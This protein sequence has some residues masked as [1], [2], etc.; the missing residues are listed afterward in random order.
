MGSN[1]P[2]DGNEQLKIECTGLISF[3][4][5]A[6][7]LFSPETGQFSKHGKVWTLL[8]CPLVVVTQMSCSV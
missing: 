8:A 4:A 5:M 7:N 2:W 1:W 3:S 6:V